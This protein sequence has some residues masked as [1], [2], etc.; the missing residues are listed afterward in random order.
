MAATPPL[1]VSSW[2]LHRMLGKSWPNRPDNDIVPAAQPTWGEGSITLLEFPAVVAR[3]GIDRVEICSFHIESRDGANL[4]RLKAALAASHVTLQSL[5]IEYGDLTDAATAERDLAWIERWIDAAAALGAE[6]ARVIAGKAKASPEALAMS[7]AGLNRLARYAAARGVA[8][9]TENWFDLLATPADVDGL[10]AKL[11]GV[12]LN[13]DFGNWDGAGKY[14]DLRAIFPRAVCCHAKGDFSS[15]AL[16]EA[17]YAA[18]L[19]AASAAGFRG[20]YTLIYDGP[21]N[22]ELAHL[23]VERDFIRRYFAA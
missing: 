2:S 19:A 18:C 7:A 9:V 4:A 14:D 13:G 21:D 11:D 16:D 10:F 3:L 20:P 1:A 17:D 5:L 6:K 22:D 8:L 12:G 15:G 23:A